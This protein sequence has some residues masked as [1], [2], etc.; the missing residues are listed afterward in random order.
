MKRLA[1]V[2][3]IGLLTSIVAYAKD[4][5]MI[6]SSVTKNHLKF[7]Q[8]SDNTWLM[9]VPATYPCPNAGGNAYT[10]F[11]FIVGDDEGYLYTPQ[12][13]GQMVNG[14]N[15]SNT[16][17]LSKSADKRNT[18]WSWDWSR[19]CLEV[20][21]NV[22]QSDQKNVYNDM[23][24]KDL[25]MDG[26]LEFT[27]TLNGDGSLNYQARLNDQKRVAYAACN[28]TEGSDNGTY[29]AAKHTT[30]LFASK[31]GDKF[32]PYYTGKLVY[33]D[34]APENNNQTTH[35]GFYFYTP[36]GENGEPNG[37]DASE[38]WWKQVG[39]SLG[40]RGISEDDNNLF[41]NGGNY[42][43][44]AVGS[45]KIST[46]FYYGKYSQGRMD[47]APGDCYDQ[48]LVGSIRTYSNKDHDMRN[49]YHVHSY[50]VVGYK[51]NTK[52]GDDKDAFVLREVPYIPKGV[53]VVLYTK[54]ATVDTLAP[55]KDMIYTGEKCPKCQDQNYLVPTFEKTQMHTY[56]Y[57]N[58]KKY[59]N[60]YLDRLYR[61][62]TW[63][64]GTYNKEQ[65][66]D[67]NAKVDDYWGF[68]SAID[69]TY[70]NAGRAYLK[71]PADDGDE[72]TRWMDEDGQA[73]AKCRVFS[74]DD[75]TATGL[76]MTSGTADK[77]RDNAY[78]TIDGQKVDKPTHGIF[79]HN[80]K[81][82]LF[83]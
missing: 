36:I 66:L 83:K 68:F 64:D 9:Y 43:L 25:V 10:G 78:Y 54:D 35:K 23:T 12:Q 30:F 27:I 18:G 1:I 57:E 82:Y 28:C 15:G 46:T 4:F 76:K 52:G 8:T 2:F 44:D 65:K 59:I 72:L 17:T 3:V 41:Q 29:Y 50:I 80:G 60:F 62:T 73:G 39:N 53:G 26:C 69:G 55:K 58:G 61:T 67:E 40:T 63:K 11:Q 31:E 33:E 13:K 70:S 19:A 75:Q 24:A 14:D 81:T 21:K 48:P 45:Y 22:P 37:W 16:G 20:K 79:I 49:R 71:Y 34:I 32:L 56:T 38:R 7:K 6:T 47:K 74:E 5:Y 51:A 42:S 77:Q